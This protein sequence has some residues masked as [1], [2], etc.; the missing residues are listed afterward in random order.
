MEIIR[1]KP[2]SGF[3]LIELIVVIGLLSLLMLAISSTMLMSIV[4]SNRIRT[5][6]SIKNA[7]NYALTQM[8][9]MLRNS[10]S[11]TTCN[12]TAGTI[13]FVNPDGGST[14]LL[15]ETVGTTTKIA[16]NSGFYITPSNAAV[17][18]FT[19][20]CEP[21]DTDPTLIKIA[22]DL[23]DSLTTK[24]AVENPTIHFETS[25]NLRNE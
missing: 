7:G 11:I 6:S 13:T 5:T 22:F 21:S 15:T 14:T 16:S 8:Q 9:A 25:V 4:S 19:I 24:R 1:K 18:G 3:S 2:L 20:L 10:R 17:S 23:K 12:S